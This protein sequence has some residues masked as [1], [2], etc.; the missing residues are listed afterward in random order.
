MVQEVEIQDKIMDEFNMYR[1]GM[2]S[3]G[4]EIATRQRRNENFNPAKWWLNPRNSSPNLRKLAIKNLD[5]TCCSSGCERNWSD[6]EQVP[7]IL[8]DIGNEWITRVASVEQEQAQDTEVVETIN[9]QEDDD[10]DVDM[11]QQSSSSHSS[12]L[13]NSLMNRMH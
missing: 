6:F 8:E 13:D 11:D 9:A 10:E 3:F 5:L 4:K 1:D 12:D 2:G 7:D